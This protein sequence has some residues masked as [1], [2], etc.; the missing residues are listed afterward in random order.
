MM[1]GTG[2][3]PGFDFTAVASPMVGLGHDSPAASSLGD[4]VAP[5]RSRE[6]WFCLRRRLG[7]WGFITAFG[8]VRAGKGVETRTGRRANTVEQGWL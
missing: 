7:V 3:T 8:G 4:A 6:R 5:P 1:V 2:G